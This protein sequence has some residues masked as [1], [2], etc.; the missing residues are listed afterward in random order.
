MEKILYLE[1]YSGIS[2]DMTVGALLD[3]GASRERLEKALE[4]LHVDGYHLHFGRTKKCGIDAYDFDVH[5]EEDGH[6][7]GEEHLHEEDHHHEEEHHHHEEDNHHHGEDHHHEG[8][9]HHPHV[10]RNLNDIYEMIDRMEEKETVRQLARKMF[11]IVAEAEAKAHGLPIDQVHFHEVGAID[12][13]VDIIST[14][15]LVDDLRVDRVIVSPLSEGRGYVRCQHGVM[16]VP[17]PA[18]AGIAEAY[19]LKLC[20]TDNE[21]EMVT[22]T[23]AAIAAALGS[24]NRLPER[25]VIRKVGI[26][27]GNKDFKN[28]NILRAMILEPEEEETG[29][30]LW[31]LETNIDDCTGEALGFVMEQ[32]LKQ[33]AKDVWHTPI[34]MKKN[35]PAVLL[36]V[37]CSE[38]DR[39]TMEEIIFIHTTTIGIRRYQVERTALK[40]R[41]IQVETPWG[42]ASA[43]VC[44]RGGR[45]W[46]A[47]EYESVK[48]ICEN[49]GISFEQAYRTIRKIGE[50]MEE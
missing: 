27:A 12:S 8:E 32:L 18:T 9:H 29:R 4:S 44:S 30:K 33:G 46:V 11:R 22:P 26:G 24:G 25:Y 34:Y 1:C 23:G 40:R 37:L 38:G 50:E 13:I 15:V 43:K 2:G 17:V 31:V 47:P 21:G 39:E 16:P 6:H 5:L 3:L 10:H 14:A 7:H 49:Q 41:E 48:S 35:R 28:A 42:P 36:S 45:P 20:L 19:G